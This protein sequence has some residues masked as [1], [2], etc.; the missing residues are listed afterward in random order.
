MDYEVFLVTRIREEHMRGDTANEAISIGFR[1]G[2]RVVVAAAVIMLS[3]FGGFTLQ[4]DP[5]IKTIAF[6]VFVDAFL[7]RMAFGPAVM[8]LLG[9]R[10]WR[11][12]AWFDRILPNVDVE[13]LGLP[14]SED[15]PVRDG[16]AREGNLTRPGQALPK[17][18]E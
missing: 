2:A 4:A 5:V 12:P 18:A 9:E 8:S 17:A 13:G 11:L 6:G 15:E 16:N 1:H 10:A 3:V 7:V 14:G